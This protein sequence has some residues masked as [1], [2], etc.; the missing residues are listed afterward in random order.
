MGNFI[1]FDGPNGSGKS[2]IIK[3]VQAKLNTYAID[4]YF[5][6]ELTNSEL[7]FFYKKS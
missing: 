1:A 3:A 4:T 7:G 2:T 5:T 6:S